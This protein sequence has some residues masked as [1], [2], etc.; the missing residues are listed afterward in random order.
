LT[1]RNTVLYNLVHMYKST[2]HTTIRLIP[3]SFRKVVPYQDEIIWIQSWRKVSFWW[4]LSQS[5]ISQNSC[6]GLPQANSW[7][8]FWRLSIFFYSIDLIPNMTFATNM[9]LLVMWLLRSWFP[10]R[11]S[12]HA[13]V[14]SIPI[15]LYTACAL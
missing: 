10:S 1:K 13:L 9:S 15:M 8:I 2:S 6:F 5:P 3:D 4:K 11:F 14:L 7:L 12:I